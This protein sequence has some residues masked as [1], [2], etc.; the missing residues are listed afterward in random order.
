MD[1]D[2][3]VRP[4]SVL[5]YRHK[6]HDRTSNYAFEIAKCEEILRPSNDQ[7]DS[8]SC[9]C[10]TFVATHPLDLRLWLCRPV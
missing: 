6:R 7:R 9:G 2:V 10:F 3:I 4:H 8:A 5:F 1:S